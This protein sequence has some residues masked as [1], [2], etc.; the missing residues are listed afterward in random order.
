VWEG[1]DADWQTKSQIIGTRPGA[2]YAFGRGTLLL[3]DPQSHSVIMTRR[4]SL[5]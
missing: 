3:V 4:D 5:N 1:L 2:F